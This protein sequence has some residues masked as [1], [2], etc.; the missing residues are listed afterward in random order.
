MTSRISYNIHAVTPGFDKGK[1]LAHLTK[2][3]PTWVL[4]MDGLQVCRDIKASVPECN[5]IHRAYANEND[6]DKISPGTWVANKVK[7]IGGADVWGYATNEAGFSDELLNWF[8]AVIELAAAVNLKVVVGNCSVGTPEA[9][10][11][12]KPAT[13]AFLKAL[14]K[15]RDT[16]VLSLHEYACGTIVSGFMGGWPDNAGVQPKKALVGRN[17]LQTWPKPDEARTM[18]K[19]HMGRFNF[20]LQACTALGIKPPRIVCTEWA[21][22]DVSDIKEWADMQPKTP[23]Y[24]TLRGWRSCVNA[25]ARWYTHW[26]AQEAFYEQLTWADKNIYQGTPVEGQLIFCWGQSSADW[27][28]FNVM[29][30]IDFQK[31][32]ETYA[33][34]QSAPPTLPEP[35]PPAIPPPPPPKPADEPPLLPSPVTRKF[36]LEMAN[37]HSALVA[38]HSLLEKRWKALAD[39]LPDDVEDVDKIAS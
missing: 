22:D 35:L 3:R 33:L 34:A 26:Q 9:T 20:L 5:V 1:L 15:H 13:I 24:T 6:W 11:W 37:G 36:A 12:K 27:E 32:L 39:S 8:T 21:F 18:T 30:A 31:R 16:A 7:E 19:F 23:P 4:V 14:D 17:L 38:V 28:T 2:I 10:D 29:D 25:W